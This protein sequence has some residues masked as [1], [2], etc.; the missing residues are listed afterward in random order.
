M[1]AVLPSSREGHSCFSPDPLRF[2]TTQRYFLGHPDDAMDKPIVHDLPS[3]EYP[4]PISS[5]ASSSIPPSPDFTPTA[6]DPFFPSTPTSSF[7]LNGQDDPADAEILLP[8]YDRDFPHRETSTLSEVSLDSLTDQQ[9]S[10]PQTPAADD[11]SIEEEPSRHVDYLSHE[12][13]EE[14]IWASWRYVV[15]RRRIYDNGVRLENAS[16]RTWAKLKQNLGTVSPE[17]LNWLKDCD[18]TWLYGP[19]KASTV[20]EKVLNVSPPPSC[21]ETPTLDMDRKSILKKRT[22][23]ETI[24]QRSLSQHTLLQHAGAILMAQEAEH[25]RSR[26]TFSSYPSDFGPMVN[27][28]YS[29]PLQTPLDGTAT[30]TSLSGVSSPSEQRHIHFNDEV[31]Q[32]IAVEAKEDD[33][34]PNALGDDYALGDDSSSDDGIV[35]KPGPLD[36]SASG[37]STPRGSFSSENKTIAPLP[38]T[39]LKYRGDTPDPLPSSIMNRWSGYLSGSRSSSSFSLETIRPSDRSSNAASLDEDTNDLGFDWDPT[40]DL[41]HSYRPWFVNSTEEDDD[42]LDQNHQLASMGFPTYDEAEPLN[43]SI[44]DKVV[45][46]VNTAKDIA[47]VIWNVG[48]RR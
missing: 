29:N 4:S 40:K 31:V 9:R 24:L 47:H 13:K 25:S 6:A 18:V 44:F 11:S 43:T 48:W 26:P 30:N 12:W 45:D 16:W 42:Q 27:K 33:E 39:T 8:C 10:S 5:S 2:P 36:A 21:S 22:A 17:A 3:K 32:C 15:A 34:W 46:T 41:D 1:T 20:R 19:L 14:D 7:S 28:S 35:M 38:S 37:R 23:S